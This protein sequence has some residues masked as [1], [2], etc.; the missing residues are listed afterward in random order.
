[1]QQKI[2]WVEV[3]MNAGGRGKRQWT[4]RDLL[5]DARCSRVVLDFLSSTDLGKREPDEAEEDAVSAVS[6]LKVRE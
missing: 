2:L 5:A 4:V 1:M 6:E 3:Q